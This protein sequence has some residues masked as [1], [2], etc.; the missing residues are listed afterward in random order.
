MN[1]DDYVVQDATGLAGLVAKGDVSPA[2]LLEAALSQTERLNPELNA[3]TMMAEGA[4]RDAIDNGLPEGP[5]RG[6]PFLLKD[7][8]AEARAYPTN[9]G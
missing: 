7:L 3:G 1:R 4:A 2:E 6:V 9:N 5:F 8:K